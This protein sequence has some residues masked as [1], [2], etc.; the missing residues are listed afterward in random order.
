MST[1]DGPATDQAARDLIEDLQL[2]DVL[3]PAQEFALEHVFE[4]EAS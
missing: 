3:E 4:L 2:A 1:H